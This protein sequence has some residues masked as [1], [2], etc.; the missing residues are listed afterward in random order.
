MATAQSQLQVSL[1]NL[2]GIV[3]REMTALLDDRTDELDSRALVALAAT[4]AILL[5]IVAAAVT[6]LSGGNRRTPDARSDAAG[7]EP[8]ATSPAYG[9]DNATRR[10]RTGALR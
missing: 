5:L 2:S 9:D 4:G 3:S 7:R 10:E 8:G 6:M 1:A